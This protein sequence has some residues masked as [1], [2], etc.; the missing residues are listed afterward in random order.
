MIAAEAMWLPPA[1]QNPLG[2]TSKCKRRRLTLL[3]CTCL[4]LQKA[5]PRAAGTGLCLDWIPLFADGQLDSPK[6]RITQAGVL[7]LVSQF[8]KD[9]AGYWGLGTLLTVEGTFCVHVLL[10]L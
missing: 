9:P 3:K 2:Q 10:F 8:P 4:K 1:L 7:D 5:A 6:E